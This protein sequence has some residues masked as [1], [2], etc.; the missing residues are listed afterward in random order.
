MTGTDSNRMFLQHYEIDM[1]V[2]QCTQELFAIQTELWPTCGLMP[3]VERLLKHL[4]ASNIPIAVATSSTREKMG[5]KAKNHQE[6]FALFGSHITCGDDPEIKN[7]KP[8]PDLFL[9]ARAKFVEDVPDVKTCLVFEDALNGVEAAQRARMHTIWVPDPNLR[10]LARPEG[11][12][13]PTETIG[14]MQEFDPSK[15]GM[16]G[17]ST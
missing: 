8:A 16:P 12:I 2:E 17:F 3:G 14:S 10:A 5:L 11:F 13:E 7:G 6:V 9:A 4:K 1:S 15:Y